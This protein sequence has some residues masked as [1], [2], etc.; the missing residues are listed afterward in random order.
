MNCTAACKLQARD[1]ADSDWVLMAFG[2]GATVANITHN[3]NTE[4]LDFGDSSKKDLYNGESS[5]FLIIHIYGNKS[6]QAKKQDR[7]NTTILFLPL[8]FYPQLLTT[9]FYYASKVTY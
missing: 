5:F 1:Q 2:S 6:I 4:K 3:H 9:V 7:L 8:T